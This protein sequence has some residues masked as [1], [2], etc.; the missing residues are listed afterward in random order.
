[1]GSRSPLRYFLDLDGRTFEAREVTG[2]EALSAPFSI[3]LRLAGGE[4]LPAEPE[5]LLRRAAA[6]LIGAEDEI[7][8][9][10]VG[11]ITEA[12]VSGVVRGAPEVRVVVEPPVALLRHRV[13]FRV[14][15]DRTVPEI[16]EE[17]LSTVG[18]AQGA[19]EGLSRLELRLSRAYSLRPYCVQC[20][21]SDLS[22]VHRL[23]EDE[24][25]HYAFLDHG[26]MVLG[27]SPA[28][29][30]PI[31][32]ERR[33]PFRPAAGLG[34]HEEAI[35]SVARRARMSIGKVSL[36]DFDLAR[37]SLSLD[38]EAAGPSPGGPELYDYP[39][40]YAD[41]AVGARKARLIAEAHACAA[42]G[43]SGRSV[44]ARLAPGRV[45]E[46]EGTP[47]G[48]GDGHRVV[49][50]VTHRFSRDGAAFSCAFDALDAAV[51]FRPPRVTPA[52]TL[53]NP[54]TG[55]VT[56][57]EG[58]DVHTDEQGRVKVRFPW[59]RRQPFDDRCSDWIP[60]LQDN[61]GHSVGIPRVGWEVMTHFLEG[62]PDRP[63]VL[64]RMYNAEDT[65]PAEL[66]AGKTKS[67]LKSMTSPGRG[68]TNQIEI[69]DASG[70]EAVSI[71][72]QKDKDVNVA[73]DKGSRVLHDKRRTVGV[74]DAIAIGRDATHWI[75]KDQ[76]HHVA[77]DETRFVGGSRSRS[78]GKGETSMVE[79]N[80][81][82][83]VGTLHF[84]RVGTD[85]TVQAKRI[86]EL[87][88]AI[89]LEASL[90]TN[91]TSAGKLLAVTVGG[92]HVEV[93][94]TD[95]GESAKYARTE[96]VGG[97]ISTTAK[98]G[99]ATKVEKRRVVTVGGPLLVD[100]K[101]KITISAGKKLEIDAAT[102]AL[103]ADQEISLK[104]GSSAVI[105]KG[106]LLSMQA[107]DVT[108]LGSG[109]SAL[110]SGAIHLVPPG[111]GGASVAPGGVPDTGGSSGSAGGASSGA[112]GGGST[113]GS[114]GT[115]G[116][117]GSPDGGA[118]S[119]D[120][121]AGSPDGGEGSDAGPPGQASSGSNACTITSQTFA[122][123]PADRARTKIGVG[124]EVDLTM[125]PG[126]ATWAITSGSGSLNP[127][128]GSYATVTFT[129]DDNGEDPEKTVTITATGSGGTCS[130]TFT[131]VQPSSV[132]MERK[133]GTPLKHH[134]GRPD[135]GWIGVEWIH[136]NDVNFYNVQ[137][138]EVDS[139]C[140]GTGCYSGPEFN[141]ALHGRYVGGFGLW[142]NVHMRDHDPAKGSKAAMEDHIYGGDPGPAVGDKPPFQ[143]GTAS[144]DIIH[145]WAVCNG[146]PH[147]F[148]AIRQEHVISADGTC[149]SAK[150]GNVEI[151]M[152]SNG[153]GNPWP[154]PP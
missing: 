25:I 142:A 47:D 14:F 44:S 94:K 92:A 105:F 72:A 64:G 49:T 17:V 134:E 74:D 7:S 4:G 54:L 150:G 130:I 96:T 48:D 66:P 5:G 135:C 132:S 103:H 53:V 19:P 60:V 20:R 13:D 43:V 65:F 108:F 27:D 46:I 138:R 24:G 90:K 143:P 106:G 12:A 33:L 115:S 146:T 128:S 40:E 3:E 89:D 123:S 114:S 87:V 145:Q 129:A 67:S 32:G 120:G 8:R 125:T 57:P 61:T 86:S 127:S 50:R 124:E 10:I 2:T 76:T 101:G 109:A 136:P 36:R 91:T 116:G 133:Q 70:R 79:G 113:G 9:T 71:I 82:L 140:V 35:V 112:S 31:A 151:T 22:F 18:L 139:R 51:P 77:S 11:V 62:D 97:N 75:G 26:G 104:V 147:D 84:R 137:R 118:G 119:P 58:E 28:A 68:G 122:T 100:T 81:T 16:A 59:D 95:K 144:F 15:R 102:G 1:M 29:H 6:V 34:G 141:G 30:D 80:R 73:H 45:L 107:D 153:A 83:D 88:G 38:V 98:A 126:P 99:I 55:F 131:V 69:D 149:V 42:A 52:P 152:Y 110:A 154:D 39:G 121:G 78:I 85:D 111:P 23:L 93:V 37:P 148:P 41:P 63:A 117:A 21:E 56:G